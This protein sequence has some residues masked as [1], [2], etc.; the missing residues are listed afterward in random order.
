MLKRIG[1]SKRLA[2]LGIQARQF[3]IRDGDRELVRIRFD[4]L[5]TEY[6]Y[7]TSGWRTSTGPGEY[8]SP[9]TPHI[10]TARQVGKA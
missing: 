8:C 4:R 3:C 1:V 6:P 2:G 9:A 5:P 10:R 7:N